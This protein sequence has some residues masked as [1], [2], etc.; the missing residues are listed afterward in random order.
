MVELN[1]SGH[2]LELTPALK[3]YVSEKMKKPLSHYDNITDAKIIL[4]VEKAFHRAEAILHISG[5][6]VVASSDD[7]DM[8][9]AI[10]SMVEKV[11]RQL[12]KYKGKKMSKTHQSHLKM[13]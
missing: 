1:I 2:H 11:T 7:E 8:Y 13:E 5:G 6:T 12:D 3:S 9:R 4:S 10:D